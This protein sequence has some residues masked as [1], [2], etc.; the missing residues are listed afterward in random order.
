VEAVDGE[1]FHVFDG[2][3]LVREW[4]SKSGPT[5]FSGIGGRSL[6]GSTRHRAP[7]AKPLHRLYRYIFKATPIRPEQAKLLNY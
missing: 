1:R 4:A 6:T 7:A 2:F 5:M 3:A